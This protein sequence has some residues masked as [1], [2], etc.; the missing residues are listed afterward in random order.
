MKSELRDISP[1]RK[2]IIIEIEPSVVRA[3]YDR[4]SDR[5]AKLARVPGFRP[6]HAPRSV[7]RARFKSE[8]RSELLRELVPDATNQAINQHQLEPLG[9]PELQLDNNEPLEDLGEKPISFQVNVEV[10]PEFSLGDYK[11]IEVAR[12]ARPVNDADVDRVVEN[13]REGSAS[14]Q[15]VEDRGAELGDIVSANFRGQFTREPGAKPINVEDVEVVLGGEGVVEDITNNLKGLK[16]D[17]VKTFTVNYPPDFSS[18]GLAGKQVEYTVTVTA[19][20]IKD[21]PDRDDEWAQ[22]LG[23]DLDSLATLRSRIRRDLDQ[24][25]RE[26]SESRLRRDLLRKLVAAHTFELPQVLLDRQTDRNVGSVMRD[27]AGRGVDPRTPGLDWKGARD[28]LKEQADFDLRASL[29][30]ERIAE[31]EKIEVTP[32]EVEAEIDAIAAASRRSP[33]QVRAVLTK[34]G[35]ERSI[36]SRL[37]NR[38]ALDLLV[39]NARVTEESWREDEGGARDPVPK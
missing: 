16:P 28:S 12:R 18:K 3:A 22:S 33:E 37:R 15:P 29:L 25:S 8:I 7:V 34:E 9:E 39:E 6:G 38:K 11:G 14:L 13:L 35:G 32:A 36:A 5:Y 24:S 27:M 19:V 31:Q 10:L 1:T 21:L 30:L 26:D 23:E 2:Q 17:D 4:I 20:R